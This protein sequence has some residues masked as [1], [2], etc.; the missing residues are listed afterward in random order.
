MSLLDRLEVPLAQSRASTM[1]VV[2]PRV[3]ASSALP[4]PTTPPPT[5]STSSSRSAIRSIASARPAG[6]RSAT[7]SVDLHPVKCAFHRLLPPSVTV[8][9]LLIIPFRAPPLGLVPVGLEL[10]GVRPEAG[11]QPG[12]V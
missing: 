12:R 3:T 11:G 6:D 9:P 4:A 2:S 5:T 10:I 8:C 7:G 1:A